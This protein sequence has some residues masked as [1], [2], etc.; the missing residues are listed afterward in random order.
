MGRI[1]SKNEELSMQGVRRLMERNRLAYTIL[2]DQILFDRITNRHRGHCS[3]YFIRFTEDARRVGRQTI[4]FG[5]VRH[6]V[7]NPLNVF[8]LKVYRQAVCT[9]M[10]FFAFHFHDLFTDFYPR[11]EYNRW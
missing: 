3:Y 10:A 9:D 7:G 6:E 8:E 1:M 5:F 4:A 11:D 2:G